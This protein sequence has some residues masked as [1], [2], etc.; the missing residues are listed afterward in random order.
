MNVETE[1]E[2]LIADAIK[3]A[4]V[5]VQGMDGKYQ[6]SVVSDFFE[7]LGAVK[8]QQAIYRLLQP[9]ISSGSIHAVSMQLQTRAEAAEN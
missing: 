2:Q 8:R 3:D 6:V 7:G 1:V 4:R 5:R 9:Y